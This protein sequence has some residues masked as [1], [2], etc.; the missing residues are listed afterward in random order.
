MN[1]FPRH[2][3]PD[4]EIGALNRIGAE[5][6]RRAA[7]LVGEGRVFSLSQTISP[8]MFVPAH[9][10]GVMHFMNRDGG[11]YAAGRKA[12]GGFQMAEDTVVM[13][14]H[15][16][17]HL[18]ALCH[19]WYDDTLYNG[20]S[21]NEIRSDGARR[22]SVDKMPPI[23]TRG[24]LLDAVRVTGAPLKDGFTM[25]PQLIRDCL[26]L[27]G[28]SLMPGDA[29]LIRTGWLENQKPGESADFNT[30]PGLGIEAAAMLADA[31]VAIVGADNY[32]VEVLPF[33]QGKVFPV[34]QKL[35][36]DCGIPLM[37]GLVLRHLGD[38]GATTFLFMAAP[39][40][41]KGGTGSPLNPVAVL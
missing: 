35:I 27:A 5:E 13:P 40:P 21:A 12:R 8:D 3:G 10:P 39:L 1:E 32:A 2:W 16:G 41:V 14:L 24:V 29:V 4:D 26:S 28:T 36:R 37:E 17:T 9:R 23:V 33:D 19:C 34:H 6:V 11:D 7:S 22:C 30:E 38:A 31:G 20:F 25:E 15:L 18:D